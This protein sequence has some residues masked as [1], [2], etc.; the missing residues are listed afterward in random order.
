MSGP[1][2]VPDAPQRVLVEG[3]LRDDNGSAAV[4]PVPLSTPDSPTQ[5]T[6]S[7]S[8]DASPATSV[9]APE[10]RA[11]PESPA[12][13]RH[14][15]DRPSFA[16]FSFHAWSRRY[17]ATLVALDA[18]VGLIAVILAAVI[19][20]E[21]VSFSADKLAVLIVGAAFAW[22]VAVAMARGYEPTNIGV[23][24]DEMRAVLRAMILAIAAGAVPSAVTSNPGLVNL[25]VV[26]TPIAGIVSLVVR[27]AVRKRLH[28]Q[29]QAGK[30]VRRV[31]VVGS[32][33][34]AADLTSVLTRESHCG[35]QVIG[36]CVPQ[37][38][39]PRA[40]EAGLAVIG[41]LE[42]VVD[43]IKLY[44]ADAV[45][46]TG[47]DATRH[48]Y[49][50]ELSWA[51]E[52]AGVELLVHPGLI[53]VAGPRMHI[54]PHVG[55]PLLH[56]EQPHFTGWRRFIKRATDLILTGSGLL[57]ISPLLAAIAI[58][59]KLEDRGPVIFRQVRVGRDGS[60]F[61]M[62]KFRS[63]HVNAEARL[64]ELRAQ[65]PYIGTMF[66]LADDPRIT[67]VGKI[68]RKF[69]LDELPQLVNVLTGSMSLVGPRPPLQS[70]VAV[71]EDAARRRL[72]VT[73][74]LTGLWQVSG[75]SLLSW[76]ETVRLDLR[77]VENWTL[78][79]DLLILW[80]TFFAVLARKGAF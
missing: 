35:M 18:V 61:T 70:E 65:N 32:V 72:L 6:V 57:V 45:A 21:L 4:W 67:R 60:T 12:T 77:Y 52:G 75:R 23:G 71:Y 19:F 25:C 3:R 7:V 41:D 51:L 63:M 13:A 47:G 50:R 73:P 56:V 17:T 54:R 20:P 39:V 66:K 49:L 53:E 44:G 46:V 30:N 38:D 26:G 22:P 27:F 42:Q 68:L 79:L 24:D 76:E 10:A 16:P 11:D 43:L 34:A 78:T 33:Y 31:I 9:E 2:P 64:S 36:V 37:M 15:D 5:S 8:S 1:E 40:H 55:L 28:H 58:A 29:Q 69:S 62:L 14:D 59:V 74:G 80:K 48:N